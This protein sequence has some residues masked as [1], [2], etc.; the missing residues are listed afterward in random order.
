MT[1]FLTSLVLSM[2]VVL[3]VQR[4]RSAYYKAVPDDTINFCVILLAALWFIVVLRCVVLPNLI[5]WRLPFLCL[6]YNWQGADPWDTRSWSMSRLKL[7]VSDYPLRYPLYG[8]LPQTIA[9][10]YICRLSGGTSS[11][12]MPVFIV[13]GMFGDIA[14]ETP[15]PRA[16]FVS[17]F[18]WQLWWIVRY[19][20]VLPEHYDVAEWSVRWGLVS[21][22]ALSGFLLYSLLRQLRART[23]TERAILGR[24]VKVMQGIWNS[25]D[26]AVAQF[27]DNEGYVF[28]RDSSKTT[29][30]LLV[31]LPRCLRSAGCSCRSITKS[32]VDASCTFASKGRCDEF[33]EGRCAL[34]AIISFLA[35]YNK[36]PADNGNLGMPIERRF[37]CPDGNGLDIQ[38][39][40]PTTIIVVSC[41]NFLARNGYALLSLP[42]AQD[43]RFFCVEGEYQ[44]CP[45]F[46][47][48]R[49]AGTG[50]QPAQA[51]VDTAA[52]REFLL[53]VKENTG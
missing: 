2:C 31:L 49:P 42:N 33:D 38:L 19:P 48:V 23:R 46:L 51:S 45:A 9:L 52:L 29:Q 24:Q 20:I 35:D 15:M 13:L 34:G 32:D 16:L 22:V 39:A 36:A 6:K 28:T 30:R 40:H 18:A 3:A 11:A 17:L 50:Q 41:A 47:G 10:G 44:P 53:A 8:L 7:I 26:A 12:Y 27:P 43:V 1:A 21:A 25:E 14:Y 5:K 37:A 4:S